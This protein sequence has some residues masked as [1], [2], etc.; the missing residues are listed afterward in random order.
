[1]RPAL[2]YPFS[3]GT[4]VIPLADLHCKTYGCPDYYGIA[5][6]DLPSVI[7]T[8]LSVESLQDLNRH[9]CCFRDRVEPAILIVTL[10]RPSICSHSATQYSNSRSECCVCMTDSRLVRSFYSRGKATDDLPPPG[11][12]WGKCLGAGSIVM[13][14]S[15][16]SLFQGDRVPHLGVRHHPC[17]ALPPR[18]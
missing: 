14:G 10:D 12:K 16:P 4:V 5:L 18:P 2:W 9:R 6:S 11:R 3:T 8:L 1:M 13:L 17:P 7:Q 15:F